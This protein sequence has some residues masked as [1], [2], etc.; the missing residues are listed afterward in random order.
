[1]EKVLVKVLI[2]EDR[3]FMQEIWRR[4]LEGKIEVISALS[5][6]EAERMFAANP[7]I[8]AVVMD[9]CVPGREI[10]TIPLVEK[11]RATFTGPMLTTSDNPAFNQ[12]LIKAG[13][14]HECLK[15][16]VPEKLCEILG[17]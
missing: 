8:V 16:K 7:G 15:E 1:M 6:E 9:A 11:I 3:E 13:C 12:M 2:V 5:I 10:N 14:N 4:I 17:L